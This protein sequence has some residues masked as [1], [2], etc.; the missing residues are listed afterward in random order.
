MLLVL[1]SPVQKQDRDLLGVQQR[2]T[3]MIKDLEHLPY[4]V[5]GKW[6]RPGSSQWCIVDRT[7][8]YGLKLEYS[9]FHTN[10]QKNFFMVRVTEHWNRLPGE[11]VESPSMEIFK[12]C[13]DAYLCHP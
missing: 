13:L 2:V 10:M 12:T 7:K 8:S 3:K 6:M 1:G 5:E 9:K 11:V 4:E